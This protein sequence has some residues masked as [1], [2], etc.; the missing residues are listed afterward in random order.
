MDNIRASSATINA[1]F[2][3]NASAIRAALSV[4]IILPLKPSFIRRGSSP[5]W[6]M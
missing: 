3:N 6:S 4:R 5:I 2:L 1:Q